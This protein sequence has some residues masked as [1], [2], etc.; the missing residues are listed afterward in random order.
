MV[1]GKQPVK[2]CCI[3]HLFSQRVLLA[4]KKLAQCR[5]SSP[6]PEV[7]LNAAHHA[8]LPGSHGAGLASN[9]CRS[10]GGPRPPAGWGPWD[11]A[12]PPG[13]RGSCSSRLRRAPRGGGAGAGGRASCQPPLCWAASKGRWAAGLLRGGSGLRITCSSRGGP[14]S[15]AYPSSPG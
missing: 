8:W 10:L 15:S 1:R 13:A 2:P 5:F 7:S 14:G 4:D 3:F 12:T 9:S 6:S 11:T